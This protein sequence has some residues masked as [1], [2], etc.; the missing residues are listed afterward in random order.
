MSPDPRLISRRHLLSAGAIAGL[1]ATFSGSRSDAAAL[2]VPGARQFTVNQPLVD[3]FVRRRGGPIGTSGKVAVAFRCDHH[4]NKF[5][6]NLLPFHRKYQIPVTV[7]AMS[8]M[9]S[10]EAGVN[11]STS[12]SFPAL[13][14][15]ALENG[16]EVAN[17]GATHRDAP[18]SQDLRN[19]IVHS[20][21]KLSM[22]LPKLPIE[23]FVPPGVG[24]TGYQGFNGGLAPSSFQRY[25][26]GRLI[27]QEHALS[28]GYT[29]GY[30]SMS[31]DPLDSMGNVHVGLDAAVFARRGPLFVQAAGQ[32]GRGVS[33]MYHP[34]SLDTAGL[35]AIEQFMAWCAAERDAGRLEILTVTGLMMSSF[36]GSIR[37]NLLSGTSS[38][39]S[40]W[41][42]WNGSAARWILQ[43][44][45]AA[46]YARRGAQ[47]AALFKDVLIGD[48]AGSVRQLRIPFRSPQGTR[49]RIEV[50]DVHFPGHLRVTRE[51]SL[52]ASADF[53]LVHQYLALPLTGTSIV[54][55]QITP[56]SGGELHVQEPQLLAA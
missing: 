16:F 19:E 35:Q 12:M 45:P 24:G 1:G 9:F 27:L 4:L 17:H 30:W 13:Q 5:I 31:G 28:T 53:R 7:A 44:E 36:S 40:G 47:S 32:L 25:L 26:A 43:K 41:N 48:H 18:T 56:L 14:R 11:G 50:F 23:L 42:G 46:W 2:V 34:S 22:S 10:I 33:F 38:F 20:K 54:R 3:A 49:V 6:Q 52:P 55:V 15:M 8:Q 39:K 21:A 37:H 51:I 29:P